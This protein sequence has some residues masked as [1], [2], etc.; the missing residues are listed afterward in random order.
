[1]GAPPAAADKSNAAC[2]YIVESIAGLNKLKTAVCENAG[3]AAPVKVEKEKGGP[4]DATAAAAAAA[5]RKDALGGFLTAIQGSNTDTDGLAALAV[6]VVGDTVKLSG[7]D[8]KVVD[9]PPSVTTKEGLMKLITDNAAT[10][11][12]TIA[13]DALKG[14]RRGKRSARR[15]FRSSKGGRRSRKGKK[16]GRRSRGCKCSK[17]C[18]CRKCRGRTNKRR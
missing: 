2:E 13:D 17:S 16:G 4:A 10:L 7:G 14:G 11:G 9:V 18:K 8:A 5:E 1:M 12:V 3:D 15:S 6:N